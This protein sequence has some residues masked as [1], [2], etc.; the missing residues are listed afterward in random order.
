MDKNFTLGYIPRGDNPNQLEDYVPEVVKRLHGRILKK[1]FKSLVLL[2]FSVNMK[3]LFRIFSEQGYSPILCDWREDFI[4]YDCGGQDLV[5]I[6]KVTSI[7]NP[8]IVICPNEIHELKSS[9]EYLMDEKF[10]HI[11]VLYDRQEIYNPFEQQQPYK[12]IVERARKRA[13]SMISD[14]ALFDL[15]QYIDMTKNVDGDVAEFGSLYGGSG[16]IIAEAVNY[17]GEKSV[18]LFDSFSGIPKSKYGL[19]DHWEGSFTDN[20]YREVDQAFK[21]MDNVKVVKGNILET[22]SQIENPISFGYIASDTLETGEVLLNFLWPKLSIG[23]IICICDYG[24]FPN[25]LPLT[26]YTDKFLRD[27]KNALVF[28]PYPFGIFIMKKAL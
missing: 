18:W 24:S 6:E 3:W 8:L 12:G 21:D 17:F 7:D 20:S 11:P 25:A 15:I 5:S 9:I 13:I 4:T 19:D 28:Y 22:Y 23:G 1:N 16:S 2:G 26:V 27:K 10:N 14:E